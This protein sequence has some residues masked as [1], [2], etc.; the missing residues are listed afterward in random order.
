MD[1]DFL[2]PVLV[3][4]VVAMTIGAIYLLTLLMSD[5]K[6]AQDDEDALADDAPAPVA[7]AETDSTV[8][9]AEAQQH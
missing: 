3:T 2:I 4:L 6:E 8:A 7:Q 5:G 9:P 1:N